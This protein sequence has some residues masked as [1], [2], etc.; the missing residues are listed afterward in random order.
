MNEKA[1]IGVM[2]IHGFSLIGAVYF[3]L[4]E[5]NFGAMSLFALTILTMGVIALMLRK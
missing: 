3:S 4:T 1:I 2:I 5:N